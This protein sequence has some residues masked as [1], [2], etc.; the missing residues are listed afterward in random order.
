MK[1]LISLVDNNNQA[2]RRN[3]ISSEPPET[4]GCY[5]WHFSEEDPFTDVKP[6]ERWAE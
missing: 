4:L 3:K 1:V 5:I 6:Q 2:R